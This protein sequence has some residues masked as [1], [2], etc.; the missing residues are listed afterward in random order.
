MLVGGTCIKTAFM[1][2]QLPP[3]FEQSPMTT[4]N[5]HINECATSVGA[6]HDGVQ[7]PAFV[8]FGNFS[9]SFCRLPPL[10]AIVP[11]SSIEDPVPPSNTHFQMACDWS[12]EEWHQWVQQQHLPAP[13]LPLQ[14]TFLGTHFKFLAKCALELITQKVNPTQCLDLITPK[15]ICFPVSIY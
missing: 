3:T 8:N 15:I 9:G 1:D 5:G 6:F 11:S 14:P 10:A 7:P 2:E 4:T 13:L 12:Q